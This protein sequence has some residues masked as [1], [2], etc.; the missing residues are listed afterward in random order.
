MLGQSNA[1]L[2]L[3]RL[4]KGLF[5]KLSPANIHPI[6]VGLEKAFRE[7]SKNGVVTVIPLSPF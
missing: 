4:V 7:N 1:T 6:V 3:T 2:Q 5:N